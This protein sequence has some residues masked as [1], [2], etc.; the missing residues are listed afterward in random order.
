MELFVRIIEWDRRHIALVHY[1]VQKGE[2]NEKLWSLKWKIW[3][4][5][6]VYD[7]TKNDN[8]IETINL[9]WYVIRSLEHEHYSY[10]SSCVGG[11]KGIYV[12]RWGKFA[13]SKFIRFT[14]VF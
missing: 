10:H 7:K 1:F 12:R 8:M 6:S 5:N 9:V 14:H 4:N 11:S 2:N 3:T 13:Y